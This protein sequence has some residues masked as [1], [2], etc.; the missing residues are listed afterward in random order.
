[1]VRILFLFLFFMI[2][3]VFS[4][5]KAAGRASKLEKMEEYKF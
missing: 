5:C 3:V 2:L 4:S 1:M